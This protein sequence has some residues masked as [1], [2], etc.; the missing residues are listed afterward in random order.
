MVAPSLE[1]AAVHWDQDSDGI[2]K[3]PVHHD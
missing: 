1:V 2:D 3:R